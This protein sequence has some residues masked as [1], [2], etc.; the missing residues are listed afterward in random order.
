[1]S[2]DVGILR[3]RY[4][5][6]TTTQTMNK[7]DSDYTTVACHSDCHSLCYS[8]AEPRKHNLYACIHEH[9]AFPLLLG[10]RNLHGFTICIVLPLSLDGS[11][12]YPTLA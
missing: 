1:M 8:Q 10:Y 11:L 3:C 4:V 9:S 6:V 7:D 12:G 5:A 2:I